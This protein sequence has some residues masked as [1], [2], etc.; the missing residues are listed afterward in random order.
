MVIDNTAPKK[1]K[2]TKIEKATLFIASIDKII[3]DI[4]GIRNIQW[5][6]FFSFLFCWN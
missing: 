1:H 3:H 6:I 4:A 5:T 2:K